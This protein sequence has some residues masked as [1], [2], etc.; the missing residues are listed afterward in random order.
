MRTPP[1]NIS[2]S[3]GLARCTASPA[4][5]NRSRRFSIT[6]PARTRRRRSRARRTECRDLGFGICRAWFLLLALGIGVA[7]SSRE[8][9]AA[10]GAPPA[11][12]VAGGAAAV[13]HGDHNPHHGGN[14][15]MKGDVHF[16]VVPRRGGQPPLYFHDA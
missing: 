5:R 4:R 7:C 1:M 3:K 15:L 13:P 2:S 14:V 11:P 6:S 10:A 16:E 8:E 12:G 9:P